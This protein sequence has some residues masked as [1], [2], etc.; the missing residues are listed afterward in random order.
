[1]YE[2]V[3]R[4]HGRCGADGA[5]GLRLGAVLQ[6]DRLCAVQG[7]RSPPVHKGTGKKNERAGASAL[8]R[9]VNGISSRVGCETS[10]RAY[11]YKRVVSHDKKL[12]SCRGSGAIFGH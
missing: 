2:R 1:M 3:H 6:Q 8:A 10:Q 11:F 9:V 5:V 7:A 4:T 12:H